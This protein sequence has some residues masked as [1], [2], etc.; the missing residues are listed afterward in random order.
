MKRILI[1]IT[2]LG[3]ALAGAFMLSLDRGMAVLAQ[4][5]QPAGDGGANAP[6]WYN[7]FSEGQG[8]DSPTSTSPSQQ[9]SYQGRLEIDGSP[10][11]GTIDITFRLWNAA[12]SGDIYWEETQTANCENGLFSVILGEVNPLPNAAYFFQQLYLGI[13]P[14]GAAEELTPRQMLGS[15]PYAMNLLP[16]AS[17]IDT[18][19][20]DAGYGAA[21]FVYSNEHPGISGSTAYNDAI[22]VSGFAMGG[23]SGGDLQPIGIYGRSYAG[24][25]VYGVSTAE[26]ENC[27]TTQ[28]YPCLAS[29]AASTSHD[30]Y[31]VFSVSNYIDEFREG[32]SAYYGLNNSSGWYAAYFNNRNTDGPA[33]GVSGDGWFFKDLYLGGSLY[34]GKLM[35]INRGSEALE[36]GDVIVVV[37]SE[38]RAIDNTRLLWVEKAT[39]E[40]ASAI[41]G[42]VGGYFEL[43]DRSQDELEP[44]ETCG[45][46]RSEVTSIQPGETMTFVSDGVFEYLKVDASSAPIHAGDL[47]SIS[48]TAG[49]AAKA[50]QITVDGYS[51]YAPGTIIGKA[52]QDLDNGTGVIAVLVSLK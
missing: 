36:R 35:A 5:S 25:G 41:V 49:V 17:M 51:F 34:Y 10:C 19:P 8:I 1:V 31:G 7:N 33:L 21:F 20:S 42:I 4:E 14:A 29:V 48:T 26:I 38:E 32:R 47:L 12:E 52:L 16:G 46:P 24:L 40:N 6:T 37:G 23:Y 9:M 18:N 44:G 11:N 45:G 50:Q 13:Q 28:S 2:I 27:V 15:V 30:N 3:L 39:P 22:G 43:C